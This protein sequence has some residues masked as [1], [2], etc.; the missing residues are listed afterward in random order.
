MDLQGELNEPVAEY[1]PTVSKHPDMGVGRMSGQVKEQVL[2]KRWHDFSS[3][4]SGYDLKH[5]FQNY[6]SHKSASHDALN[7]SWKNSEEEEYMWDDITSRAPHAT[8]SL[9][10]D[11]WTLDDPERMVSL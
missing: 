2:D 4:S 5:G 11:H 9:V 7:K 3:K 1:G 10:K 6:P 8:K